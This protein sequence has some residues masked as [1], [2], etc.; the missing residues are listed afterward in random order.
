MPYSG[1]G[2]NGVS[3]AQTRK[4]GVAVQVKAGTAATTGSQVT[5]TPDAGYIGLWVVTVANGQTTITSGN[6]SL[7]PGAPLV[8]SSMA[9]R[10]GYGAWLP[11]RP[12]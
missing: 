4:C 2:G 9:A 7:Y 6:I 12:P 1:A 10:P 3:Q 5:P 11:R 8:T